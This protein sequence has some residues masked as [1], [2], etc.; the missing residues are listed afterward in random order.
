MINDVDFSQLCS[1]PIQCRSFS[2]N[3]LSQN[4]A[5]HIHFN[6]KTLDNFSDLTC[7]GHLGEGQDE[8]GGVG[9]DHTDVVA[10]H[11]RDSVQEHHTRLNIIK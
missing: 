8:G 10:R 7:H 2:I 9:L 3:N 11:V 6:L 4:S 1:G 5:A